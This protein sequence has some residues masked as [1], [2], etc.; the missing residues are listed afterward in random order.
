[1]KYLYDAKIVLDE[2]GE[3]EVF[4]PDVP[5]VV[6]GGK[7]YAEAF[8][9]ASE[10]LGLILRG[11]REMGKSLP[12]AHKYDGHIAVPVNA[13]DALKLAVIDAFE[14]AGITKREFAARLHKDEKEVHRILDPDHPTKMQ[15]LSQALDILGKQVIITVKDAVKAAA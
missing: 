8:H 2:Y 7:S 14:A 5:E 6:T 11:Y 15:T 13:D 12:A 10:A 4:F 9:N 1:M 3:F